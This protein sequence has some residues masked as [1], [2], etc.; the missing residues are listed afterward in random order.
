ML[1]STIRVKNNIPGITGKLKRAEERT[2]REAA[3][4]AAEAWQKFMIEELEQAASD[5]ASGGSGRKYRGKPRR[6]AALNRGEHPAK[7]SGEFAESWRAGEVEITDVRQGAVKVRATIESTHD[8][9]LEILAHSHKHWNDWD[10]P[11]EARRI[12]A[13]VYEKQVKRIFARELRRA[14][15]SR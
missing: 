13:A 9:V 2:V 3:K 1:K 4:L 7:Q 14:G 15:L 8:R 11:Y 10:G 5:T 6:S 12:F